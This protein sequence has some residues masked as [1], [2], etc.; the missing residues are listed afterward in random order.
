MTWLRRTYRAGIFDLAR[1]LI[2][3]FILGLAIGAAIDLFTR[4]L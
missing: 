3:W 4:Y 1:P 2:P